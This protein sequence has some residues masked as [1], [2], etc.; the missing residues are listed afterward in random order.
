M[1]SSREM[2]DMRGALESLMPDTCHIL[3]VTNTSDGQ[4]GLTQ[5]WGTAVANVTCRIDSFLSRGLAS[6]RGGG[7]M[8]VG[9]ALTDFSR[10]IVSMPYDTAVE[11]ANRIQMSDGSV[12]NIVSLDTGKSWDLEKRLTVEKV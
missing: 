2:L 3:E 11:V 10:W 1:L 8:V 4:G 12:Y 5:A 6:M 7:E 9:G